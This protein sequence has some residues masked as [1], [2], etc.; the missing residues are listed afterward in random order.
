MSVLLKE[1]PYK[2]DIENIVDECL[3]FFT[4]SIQTV[5]TSIINTLFYI[6][7]NDEL[8]LKLLSEIKQL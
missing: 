8:R 5:V 7:R 1:E 2:D 4:A 6:T 3:T